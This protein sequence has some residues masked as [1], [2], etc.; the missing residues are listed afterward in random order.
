MGFKDYYDKAKSIQALSDKSA[1]QI[2]DEVESAGYHAEDIIREE[3]F[4]PRANFKFPKNFARYGSAEEY[5]SLALRKIY[6]EYPYD[7]SLKERLEWENSCTYLDLH[8]FDKEYPRTNG[9]INL[10]AGEWGTQ[11]SISEGYG[12]P[13]DLEYIYLKGGPH[14]NPDGMIPYSTQFTG[15]N[16]YEPA[17][18]REN[19]LKF[20][21][22]SKGVSIEFWLK[23]EAFDTAKTEKEVIFDLWNGRELTKAGATD[24]IDTTG[25]AASGAD[26]SFNIRLEVPNA[27]ATGGAG[28]ITILLDASET[29]GTPPAANQIGIGINGESDSSIATLI[30]RAIN[31][32]S[33]SRIIYAPSGRGQY[34]VP[35]MTATEGS[36]NTQITFTMDHGG[37]A[38]NDASVFADVSGVSVVDVADI[39]AGSGNGYGRLRLELTGASGADC[40]RLTV[41]SGSNGF[42]AQS[43]AASTVTSEAV[44][45]GVWHHYGLTL[46]SASNGVLSNFYL[47]GTLNNSAVFGTSMDL[48]EVTGAL[49]ANIGALIATP[50]SSSAAAYAGKLSASLDEFRYWKTE[51]SGQQIGRHWFTQVG[52]GTNDD[53]KPFKETREKANTNLG[54]YYKF[55]EGITGVAATDSVVLDYSGR[56]SNGTW[57]GYTSDSRATGSAIVL[58]NAAIKE[59]KDPI[60]YAFHPEVSGLANRLQL[61]GSEYDINNNAAIYNSIPS[62]ITEED[63]EGQRQLKQLIQIMSS[64][65]DTLQ[66]QVESL[67]NL[68]DITYASGSQKPLPFADRLLRSSGLMAPELFI[69]AD[70]LE[71]LADRS[72]DRLYEKS[73]ADVK[74]TIYQN[75]YNNLVYIY[76]TKGTEKAFR[77]LI[78][79]FGID[80]ELVKL[81]MYA[82]GIEYEIRD[83]RRTVSVV[84][85]FIDFN[86]EDNRGGTVFQFQDPADTTNTTGFIPANTRLSGGFATTLEADILFP[87]KPDEGASFY[88]NTNTISASLFGVHTAH[89]SEDFTTW[90]T[91]PTDTTNFQVYA[92]RDELT[93]DSVRFVLT[94]TAGGRVPPLVSDLY[95][96]VY[97]N[98]YWNLAVRIKPVN[99]PQAGQV[100]GAPA[101]GEI[102]NYVI[103]LHG[104]QLDAGVVRNEFTLTGDVPGAPVGFVTGS[105]RAYIGAHRT[106]FTGSILETSD[107]KVNA[108]RYWLDYVE[109]ATLV[110]HAFDTLNYGSLQPHRYAFPFLPS[111]SFGEVL[112]ADTLMFNWE[113]SQNTGSNASGEF[114]VIDQYSGSAVTAGSRFDWLGNFLGIQFPG[115]GQNFKASSIKV[116]DK[117]HVIS[118]KLQLPENV[119]SSDMVTVLGA[120][121]QKIL[122]RDSRPINYFFAFEKSMAQALSAEMINYFATLKDVNNLIG[123]PVNRYRPEYKGLKLLRQRF[124]ERVGNTEIDF[125]KFY[126]FYKWFD[127]SL[128]VMLQQL[129]PASADFAENVRTI[130]ESHMLER[131]KYQSKFQNVK[132]QLGDPEGILQPIDLSAVQD[133]SPD[134]DATGTGFYSAN[135]QGR[136]QIGSSQPV[137]FRNWKFQHAPPPELGEAFGPLDRNSIWWRAEAARNTLALVEPTPD[138]DPA[139]LKNKQ[140]ILK[141][142]IESNSRAQQTPYKFGAEGNST[143]GGVGF[144]INKKVDFVFVATSPFGGLRGRAAKNVMVGFRNEVEELIDTKDVYWPTYKQRLGF[145]MNP[146]INRAD[147]TLHKGDGNLLAPFSIYSSSVTTGQNL[148]VIENY[149]PE[150]EITNLHHDIV[151][152]SDSPMQGPFPEKYVGGRQYRHT[153]LNQGSDNSLY[154]A[155][156]WKLK[157]DHV[158]SADNAAATAVDAIDT[159]GVVADGGDCT[160]TITIP[161]ANGGDT[162]GGAG[163]I[164]I[165]LDASETTGTPAAADQIG[166]GI[167]GESDSSIATLI[168][169]AINNTS[170]SRIIPASAGSRGT[171]GVSGITAAEGS[172]NTQLTLTMDTVGVIGNVATALANVSGPAIVDVTDFTGGGHQSFLTPMLGIVPPNYD[173]AAS[174]DGFNKDIPTGHRLRNVGTKRPVNIQNVKMTTSSV[175]TS[176]SGVLAHGPIGNYTK[177]Y[178][179]VQSNAR[180]KND[181]FFNDQSFNF[182]LTPE[183]L[184]TRGRF[185]LAPPLG[186]SILLDSA[187]ENFVDLGDHEEWNPLIGGTGASAKNFTISCW[188]KNRSNNSG[189]PTNAGK[190]WNFGNHDVNL[191]ID[192]ASWPTHIQFQVTITASPWSRRL[193]STSGSIEPDRWYHVVTQ[194]NAGTMNLYIDGALNNSVTYTQNRDDIETSD[195]YLG[196]RGG[197]SYFWSGNMCDFVVWDRVLSAAEIKTIYN[198]GARANPQ[199][200]TPAG[201]LRWYPLGD[202][203]GDSFTAAGQPI[204]DVINLTNPAYTGFDTSM[205]NGGIDRNKSGSLQYGAIG[206]L[207]E[208]VSGNLDYSLPARMGADSNQSIIVNRFT[209]GGAGYEVRSRGYMDPAHEEFSVYNATPYRSPLTLNFGGTGWPATGSG[210][211]PQ[212]TNPLN[213]SD[214]S[215][216]IHVVDQ[217][218]RTRGLRQLETLHCG[219][220]GVDPA[221]GEVFA[222][223]YVKSPAYHK[224]NRNARD[225]IRATDLYVGEFNGSSSGIDIGATAGVLGELMGGSGAQAKPFT[226]SAWVYANE[227]G[228][229]EPGT[230]FE[231]GVGDRYLR[232]MAS[233][234]QISFVIAGDTAGWSKTSTL[235]AQRWYHIVATFT[236]GDPGGASD[237]P[238]MRIYVDAVDDTTTEGAYNLDDPDSIAS[239]MYLGRSSNSAAG[240]GY[241]NGAMAN[242]LIWN[243][244]L[245]PDE[246]TALYN[247]RVIAPI[248]N[249]SL[250][251]AANSLSTQR[252][253]S[254]NLLVW[255]RFDPSAGDGPLDDQGINYNLIN[256]ANQTSVAQGAGPI[257]QS[258]R[259]LYMVMQRGLDMARYPYNIPGQSKSRTGLE[260]APMQVI[261]E[262]FYDNQFIQH[263]IPRSTSQYSWVTGSMVRLNQRPPIADG[264]GWT[265]LDGMGAIPGTSGPRIFGL[266]APSCISASVLT[267]LQTSSYDPYYNDAQLPFMPWHVPIVESASV[268]THLLGYLSEPR[269]IESPPTDIPIH[270]TRTVG[271]FNKSDGARVDVGYGD[272]SSWDGW[273][274]GVDA[275]ALPFTIAAWVNLLEPFGTDA[276]YIFSVGREAS[277][278]GLRSMYIDRKGGGGAD[279]DDLMLR[280]ILWNQGTQKIESTS[281]MGT[282]EWHHVVFT[283][284]GGATGLMHLFING[285]H[286]RGGVA[287]TDP[288]AIG[289]YGARIGHDTKD[290]ASGFNGLIADLAIYSRG[291]NPNTAADAAGIKEMYEGG[292]TADLNHFPQTSPHLIYWNRLDNSP[293]SADGLNSARYATNA[294][295]PTGSVSYGGALNDVEFVPAAPFHP[296]MFNHMLRQ[297]H[298]PYGY[299]IWKQTRTGDHP[300][301]RKLRENNL[302]GLLHPP[303]LIRASN[304]RPLG[305]GLKSNNFTDYREPVVVYDTAKP[306]EFTFEDNAGGDKANNMTLKV[307]YQNNLDY[308]TNQGLNWRLGLNRRIN[309]AEGNAFNAIV[310]YTF[311]SSLSTIVRYGQKIFPRA[312][313]TTKPQVNKRERYDTSD[314]WKDV[315]RLRS[316]PSPGHISPSTSGYTGSA[317]PVAVPNSQGFLEPGESIWPL[318][319]PLNLTGADL[320]A[321][322]ASLVGGMPGYQIQGGGVMPA[323]DGDGYL[324]SGAGELQ[325]TYARFG[326]YTTKG[327]SGVTASLA[328]TMPIRGG[329]TVTGSTNA[330]QGSG[331]LIGGQRWTAYESASAPYQPYD[332]Y[333]KTIRLLGKN[334]SI[335]PEF[336]I[337]EHLGTFVEEEGTNFLTKLDNIFNLTG[338][339]VPDSSNGKFYQLYSATDFMKYFKVVDGELADRANAAGEKMRRH[340]IELSCDALLQF[341]PYKGFYPAERT[342]E[343]GRLLSQSLGPIYSFP[344]TNVGYWR[345][346]QKITKRILLEPLM[347]P[348]ILFNTIKSGIA[349]SSLVLVGDNHNA[350][351]LTFTSS[352]DVS[353][354]S[355]LFNGNLVSSGQGGYRESNLDGTGYH[356]LGQV[357]SNADTNS[358]FYSLRIVSSGS[359]ALYIGSDDVNP[360]FYGQPIPFEAIRDPDVYLSQE[361]IQSAGGNVASGLHPEM[362]LYDTGMFSA[363]LGLASDGSTPHIQYKGSSRSPLYKWGIDNFLCETI[364]FFQTPLKSFLSKPE[365][366]FLSVEKDQ[367][368][369]LQIKLERTNLSASEI[370]F[371]FEKT[372]GMYSRDSAFGPAVQ[373]RGSPGGTGTRDFISYEPWLPP[374]W[375]GQCVANI[376]FKAPYSGKA[377]LD[378]I[379]GNRVTEFIK[380]SADIN[381]LGKGKTF[382]GSNME[383][384]RLKSY[385]PGYDVVRPQITSS[386]DIF[387]K[388][389]VVAPDTNAQQARWLIQ[390]K[391]EA[392]VLNFFGVPASSSASPSYVYSRLRGAWDTD[393]R[394]GAPFY[395]RLN[396][397]ADGDLSAWVAPWQNKPYIRGM[398]H[399][400]G[401][402]PSGSEGIHL[403]VRDMPQQYSSSTYGGFIDVKP[404]TKIV[405]ITPSQKRIGD[406]AEVKKVEEAIVCVP[407]LTV[408][409]DRKFF[410]VPL[411]TQEYVTQLALLNKYVFPPTFDFLLHRSVKPI[412][413]YAF[414]FSLDLTQKDLMDIWQNCAPGI[415]ST[416]KKSTALIQVTDLVDQ[417]LGNDQNLQWMVF[418]VKR[419]AEKDYNVFTRKGLAE[420]LPIVQPALDTKY[421]YNWPYDYFSFV[422]LVKIDETIVYTTEDIIPEDEEEIPVYPDLREFIPAP[423]EIP[424]AVSPPPEII[425][426]AIAGTLTPR[427]P[428]RRRRRPSASRAIPRRRSTTSRA[429]PRPTT[430]TRTRPTR[431]APPRPTRRRTRANRRRRGRAQTRQRSVRQVLQRIFDPLGLFSGRPRRRRR[432]RRRRR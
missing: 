342:I 381:V 305:R 349:C 267:G 405:G 364:N 343:L 72:E 49:R 204:Y 416:F 291:F 384:L 309:P 52:G 240:Q 114:T 121:E 206:S 167:L 155:E 185:P 243:R 154:R 209:A 324:G 356:H 422:E 62:W 71:K 162:T 22:L 310:D 377:T 322:G 301:A 283:F 90:G 215:G 379:L 387:E 419:R 17:L 223:T 370:G 288:Y 218:G 255:A 136:R 248:T 304:G 220:F 347:A 313:N 41:L 103:E 394:G 98:T 201:L 314:I 208:N 137:N 50:A 115:K 221:Y 415:A 198:G 57:T 33:N 112:K 129:V 360:S 170:N 39:T 274:G 420:G 385:A 143:L 330:I 132:K 432:R 236:G 92:V 328:Y 235:E 193:D 42:E 391:F 191:S 339:T 89:D 196:A 266:Q 13:A 152:N 222:D 402:L 58:S 156:G 353:T 182:A 292:M 378:D 18:N 390:P 407:F 290:F 300:V 256:H 177:N 55:N 227:V 214:I 299:P 168:K 320:S 427:P 224:T 157:F 6:E 332:D 124:F 20:D 197:S 61:T 64:Y 85:K 23:K 96:E 94:G 271:K 389:L 66:L 165:L 169:R 91:S 211:P 279:A 111:A 176:L 48:N 148:Q 212:R 183:T 252:L 173:D 133:A 315:R 231:W 269:T 363:S 426:S 163:A 286:D 399:Q 113:F 153:E 31:G 327:V 303:P 247:N 5:Y 123:A 268:G 74:N 298:G 97:D 27:D 308:F 242:I 241:W 410:D 26:C 146:D 386:V 275:A 77:N 270:R 382:V 126:E 107:V 417:M 38:W 412:A 263:Q 250:Y 108:C 119:Q 277:N 69:D 219:P 375:Y 127:S 281:V 280:G 174:S 337:S 396:D 139:A 30:R 140:V 192:G 67:S 392:P 105:K 171:A 317:A 331:L 175:G 246:V 205:S 125:E 257:D 251:P 159:T 70:V 37:A 424:P 323:A 189:N 403:S 116:V 54:V 181:P 195:C 358:P 78:R 51:R 15:A 184:A 261:S 9:Y 134:S 258:L 346:A 203:P 259:P 86:T 2:G 87:L 302:I 88:Y 272:P 400:Y 199:R 84:D 128:T 216:T 4:I 101:V 35:P 161:A 135:A 29:T 334:M 316:M 25:V 44:A 118:S 393:E 200:E 151:N 372:F 366:E 145:Q 229:S 217:L 388:L 362:Y 260:T 357:D 65:F 344:K 144:G 312:H 429:V 24:A 46:M 202:Y 395:V 373:L 187:G 326:Y 404:L 380:D 348:G 340:T 16:Y 122:T 306:I 43:V 368:Y 194:Y 213:S 99:Y 413:F 172:S 149:A 295:F 230:L 354:T 398:W 3:R 262:R 428:R 76:K 329:Q 341:L 232:F 104:V 102:S 335:V 284:T 318:D 141:S 350:R 307:S 425:D 45:D 374:H 289:T 421:S 28:A 63:E 401:N 138:I 93:S 160:I 110:G 238:S 166:I 36:S 32:T 338:A 411:R 75:I 311:D 361:A 80:D 265:Y 190:I 397:D 383:R 345:G 150:I 142:T 210:M 164:T 79:C 423:E 333:T 278:E 8:V 245:G 297:R 83:N 12:L 73:L 355:S 178:E 1:A 53:P 180:E 239:G 371:P 81:N 430:R 120:Q 409:G 14:P 336:R 147:S 282:K 319:A 237:S 19:N 249:Q 234:S 369:G 106:N 325:N 10:S 130:I 7:G 40:F 254:D 359:K 296:I 228:L 408:R 367:Y 418:K 244:C 294:V 47:D 186:N 179:V 351:A 264:A 225:R 60:I 68:K 273:I 56:I 95:E 34:G 406:F 11:S 233:E 158:A 253:L 376:I 321:G 59:F 365:E 285:V 100:L 287:V 117:D 109:D 276:G 207:T 82:N 431:S 188:I 131:S 293:L 352:Y 21:L 414:E 226:F